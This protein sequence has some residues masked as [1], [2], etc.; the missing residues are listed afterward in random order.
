MILPQ[1]LSDEG[2]EQEKERERVSD[3]KLHQRRKNKKV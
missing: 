2:R 1:E 3:E